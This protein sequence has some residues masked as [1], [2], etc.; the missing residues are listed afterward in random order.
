MTESSPL[1][2]SLVSRRSDLMKLYEAFLDT[3]HFRLWWHERRARRATRRKRCAVRAADARR[4][5][6]LAVAISPRTPMC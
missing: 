3:P 4:G 1:P 5:L 2:R 6:R